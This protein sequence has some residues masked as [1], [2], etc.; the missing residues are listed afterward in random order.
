MAWY[1]ANWQYRQK[2]TI[3]HTKVPSTQTNIPVYVNL[4]N[5]NT[6]FF[7]NVKSDGSDIRVTQS[8][9]TTECPFELVAISVA[10]SSGE[11]HFKANSL[12]SIVDTD[13]YIYY[14]YASATAYAANATYGSQNVWDAN[15]MGVYHFEGNSNDSTSNVRN[16]TDSNM[17]Y[18]TSS[19]KLSGQ[20]AFFNGSNSKIDISATGLPTTGAYTFEAWFNQLSSAN[21]AIVGY[22]VQS[23]NNTNIFRTGNSPTA[24]NLVNYWWGND[25]ASGA[26]VF[27]NGSF[28][29]GV[30]QWDG[31]TRKILANNSSVYSNADSGLNTTLSNGMIGADI[32]G[33]FFYGGLDEI[34]ISNI[35]RSANWLTT[36]YNNQ[37]SPST[38]YTVGTQE[39][40]GT[41][42]TQTLTETVTFTSSLIRTVNRNL[43]ETITF[44]ANAYRGI[45]RNLNET[46]TFTANVIKTIEKIFSESITFTDSLVKNIEKTLIETVTFTANVYK[47][48]VKTLTETVN[49]LDTLADLILNNVRAGLQTAIRAIRSDK[50]EG[51][52]LSSQPAGS[53]RQENPTG[54]VLD[55]KPT[56]STRIESKP[57]RR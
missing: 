42:Y 54:T 53:V 15:Y 5:M 56:G 33:E 57:E 31:T 34:R 46:I 45:S 11:L 21:R 37:N 43:N 40:N 13:F 2:V 47:D 35:A 3:D 10:G 25:A 23:T 24:N 7:S 44:T 29:Y 49:F 41:A 18:A 51:E 1:N 4:A 17:A 36:T 22:G 30:A 6:G 39:T 48:I 27:T 38:F 55:E 12:S 50:P 28:C 32:G 20:G 8:D 26:N 16:G 9:G 52:V 14:G 19:G